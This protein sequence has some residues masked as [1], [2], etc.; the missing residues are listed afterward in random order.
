M[1][2]INCFLYFGRKNVRVIGVVSDAPDCDR[3][4]CKRRKREDRERR[5]TMKNEWVKNKEKE[6]EAE[7]L[8]Y[9]EAGSS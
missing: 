7:L 4:R 6:E 9:A 2:R 3:E 5:D 8:E 1:S